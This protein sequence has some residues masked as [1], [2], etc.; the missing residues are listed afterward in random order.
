[1]KEKLTRNIGLKILSI[2]LAALLWLLITNVDDPIMTKDFT[3]VAVDI[4]HA[5]EIASLGQVYEIIEGAN[6]NFTVAARR[7]VR[8]DLNASDFRVTADLA[9]LSDVNAVSIEIKCP[10]YGD[11][12]S[13]TKGL[14]QVMK[15]KLEKLAKKSIKVDVLQKGKPAKGFY[16]YKK[17]TNTI[18][19]VFG[20]ESKIEKIEQIAVEVDVTDYDGPSFRTSEKPKALD[21]EGNEIDAS[22][23]KFSETS[24]SAWIGIYKTK[25]IN[26]EITP[27]GRPADGYT[28]ADVD[29]EPKKI[30]IAAED[31]LLNQID[32]ITVTE[33]ITGATKDIEKEINLQEQLP[34][35]VIL[36]GESPT[37]VVNVKIEE[38]E[39]KQISYEPGELEVKNM[40]SNLTLT[41]LMTGPIILN[42]KGPAKELKDIT[43]YNLKPYIDISDYSAGLHTV[44]IKA[45]TGGYSY[46]A[47]NPTVNI[48]LV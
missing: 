45:E 47:G 25:K 10:R 42:V 24:I 34:E 15:V 31:Y 29:Y 33:D 44:D 38:A 6:I 11:Q 46:L 37:A 19:N 7:S 16:V 3:N 18:I 13:I 39:T 5:N 28:I 22:N 2:L 20:P 48:R 41:Y 9:K 40:P 32:D 4:L 30:E 8:D 36:V 17:N 14:N 1:M 43:E 35:G 23:L 27:T 21:A 26:V 12:I